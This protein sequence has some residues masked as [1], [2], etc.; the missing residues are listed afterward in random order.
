M[1]VLTM[2]SLEV[3]PDAALA[4]NCLMNSGIWETGDQFVH[5]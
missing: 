1:A 4:A 2:P 3:A 5:K